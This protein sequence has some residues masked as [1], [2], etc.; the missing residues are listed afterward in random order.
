MAT[1]TRPIAAET[2]RDTNGAP[3]EIA[4]GVAWH[5][6]PIVNVYFLG[7]PGSGDRGWVLVDAGL[8]GMSGG[9]VRAAA[10]RFGAGARP[11]AIILTHG[12]FDHT[13]ALRTLAERWDAPIY[14][15][16]LELPYLTGR[17]AYPPPDPSVGGGAMSLSSPL[18]PRGPI[19]LGSRVRAFPAGSDVP[20]ASG[21][22]V[23]HTPGHSPGHVSLWREDDRTLIVGDAFVTT[24]Q[25]SAVAAFTKPVVMHGPPMYFTPDWDSSRRSVEALAAL[26]PAL[27]ATGHG[28]PV[29]GPELANELDTLART[30]DA[31]AVPK[32]G[33]YVGRRAV[34]D[35]TGVVS[36]P[37]APPS[38]LPLV[39][40]ASAAVGFAL[41]RRNRRKRER[42]AAS[43]YSI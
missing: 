2:A 26:R 11:S 17:S 29:C 41:A 6:E 3:T 21:W 8:P 37:P 22:H 27:A 34:A 25:E 4:P 42:D 13:G 31:R 20:G 30:F 40:A 10:A 12:H 39:L 43:D 23:I 35:E 24:V 15:H 14:A 16:P 18:F 33:R 38:R 19:D 5:A 36:V 9:I 32:H 28:V 7:T 1:E